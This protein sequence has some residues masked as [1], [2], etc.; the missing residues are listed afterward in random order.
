MVFT[1]N[2]IINNLKK[3]VDIFCYKYNGKNL[4]PLDY[5]V[6][7]NTSYNNDNIAHF[8]GF[9]AKTKKLLLCCIEVDLGRISSFSSN[10]VNFLLAHELCHSLDMQLDGDAEF[11][12]D[13]LVQVGKS[14]CLNK[15]ILVKSS[16]NKEDIKKRLCQLKPE[17]F[18]LVRSEHKCIDLWAKTLLNLSDND[19]KQCMVALYNYSTKNKD[20]SKRLKAVKNQDYKSCLEK[21]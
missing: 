16:P 14:L 4:I 5:I 17:Q 8:C 13:G 12:V 20:I 6:L 21:I 11:I 7:V 18:G 9:I 3:I 2:Q 19:T 1:E 15:V 10:L